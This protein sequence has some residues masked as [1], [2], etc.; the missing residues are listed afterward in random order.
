MNR[1]SLFLAGCAAFGV[2]ASGIAADTPATSALNPELRAQL[3]SKIPGAKPE[4]IRESP[5]PGLYEVAVDTSVGYISADGRYVIS[6]D[7]F[8]IASRTN[9]TDVRKADTRRKLLA[10]LKED[11]MIIFAPANVKHTITVFTDVDCTYCRKLH[12]EI[13]ELNKLGVKVRYLAYPRTG[14]NTESW[15]KM[16]QVFC[17]KDRKQ[18][19][20]SAK[21]GESVKS[22]GCGTTPVAS[23]FAL[24]EQIGVNG[25]PAIVT[26]TGEYIGGYLPAAKLVQY[27]ES[28]KRPPL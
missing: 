12:S 1:L 19:L 3:A 28:G 14:P 4:S 15:A 26:E 5:I 6:G 22:P 16:E 21:R 11:Q 9:L 13:G 10:G 27:L 24:G 8:E 25:T 17:S 23:E 2:T 7:L 20:T 18:A